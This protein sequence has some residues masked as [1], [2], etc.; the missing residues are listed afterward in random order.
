MT[1]E[2]ETFLMW[3]VAGGAWLFTS[4]LISWGLER[5]DKWQGLSSKTKSVVILFFA[6]LLGVLATWLL[7]LPP[8][9]FAKIMPYGKVVVSTIISWAVLQG[10]H[11][12]DPRRASIEEKEAKTPTL[13]KDG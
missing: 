5:W 1:I 13:L 4:W 6:L 8:E 9:A 10:F 3:L 12:K 11:Y 2:L 7:T